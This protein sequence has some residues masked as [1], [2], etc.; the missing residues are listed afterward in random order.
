MFFLSNKLKVL[1]AHECASL[2]VVMFVNTSCIIFPVPFFHPRRFAIWL[3]WCAWYDVTVSLSLASF[4]VLTPL[5]PRPFSLLHSRWWWRRVMPSALCRWWSA[6]WVTVCFASKSI[7]GS[8]QTNS[9]WT[10]KVYKVNIMIQH[11]R[12]PSSGGSHRS[13]QTTTF[14]NASSWEGSGDE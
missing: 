5:R 6:P 3:G 11:V 2:A 14:G 8:P 13:S 12:S 10:F 7:S 1:H 4:V 9:V